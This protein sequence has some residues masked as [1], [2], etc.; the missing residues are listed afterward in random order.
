[1]SR[2]PGARWVLMGLIVAALG[3][4]T[5]T[6]QGTAD[7]A[8]KPA[9]RDKDDELPRPKADIDAQ[10][11]AAP[12]SILP[13]T[14]SPID[15]PSTLRLAGVENPEILIARQRVLEAVALRQLAA[16][17]ILPNLNF[18]LNIDLHTGVL[19]QSSGNILNVNRGAMYLGLGANAV[20]A[21]TVGIPGL[22]YNVNVS[23]ALFAGLA[24]RQVVRVRQF[25]SQAVR[26]DVLLRTAVAYVELLRAEGLRAVAVQNRDDARVIA[27]VT[28]AYAET[29][30]GTQADADRAATELARRNDE[31][32]ATEGRVLT[33]SAALAQLL[34]L[35]PST[36]LLATDGWVV[37]APL[38]PD[39]IP[40][41]ELLFIAVNQRP[42]LAAR[43]AAIREAALLL[44]GAKL[45]PFSPNVL[46]GYSA[47]TFGGGSNLVSQPGGFAGFQEGRFDQ[48]ST[49]Q[50]VDVVLYWTAQ[51]MGV[52][53]LAQVR[54]QRSVLG[55][56]NLEM[57]RVLNQV[58]FEVAAAYART[59]TRYAE[60]GIAEGAVQSG[61]RSYTE[62]LRRVRALQGRPIELLDSFRL[63]SAARQQYLDAISD[64]NRA[65]FEL[66]VALGQPPADCLARPIPADLVP[67]PAAAPPAKPD[68]LPAAPVAVH[69]DGEHHSV[70]EPRP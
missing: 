26:N 63:L 22:F 45:L 43:R 42:E 68:C 53:N 48:F 60:I 2:Y 46:A 18:G 44:R 1:M 64:Y 34:N 65:Q 10:L 59:H 20:A 21:G 25:E 62:D 13:H 33:A 36:V 28:A 70:A 35:D 47:G 38:V 55:E 8:D 14:V 67:P 11:P 66:Y 3:G 27:R 9:A 5:A 57:V 19:Q 52:G 6:A 17:Q 23:Q 49:R 58:R 61:Q 51:N 41:P 37:P 56:R 24:V 54:L 39:P 32:V 4:A 16:A 29:G 15:L 12:P 7:K 69:T 31:V 40:L 30:Q 50:D